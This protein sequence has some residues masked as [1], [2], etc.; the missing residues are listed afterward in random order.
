M[1]TAP[2]GETYL[3]DHDVLWW[4]KGGILHGES[5]QRIAFLREI[6]EGLPGPI[7]NTPDHIAGAVK[8][9]NRQ[10]VLCRL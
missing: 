2:H 9:E 8:P 7:E 3:H 1:D 5:P 4:A 6:V 10:R